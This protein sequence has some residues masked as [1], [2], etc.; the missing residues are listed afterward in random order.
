[1]NQKM[2]TLRQV[3]ETAGVSIATVSRVLNKAGGSAFTHQTA[4]HVKAV[5]TDLGYRP[6][7]LMRGVAGRSTRTVGVMI[8]LGMYYVHVVEGVH[9][10]LEE[11]DYAMILT[12]KRVYVPSPESE[13]ERKAMHRLLDRRVDG[14]ILRPTH[15]GVSDLYFEE[16]W[17]RGIPMVAVDR[18]LL[19]V[20]CDYVGT[21]NVAAGRIAAEHLLSLGHR[22]LA[23][24]AGPPTVSVVRDRRKGFEDAVAAFGGA[25]CVTVE[26]TESAAHQRDSIAGLLART[27]RPTGLFAMNDTLAEAV[28]AVAAEQGLT[29]PDDLSIVGCGNLPP[30]QYLVPSL[31]SFEQTPHAIGRQAA[32]FLLERLRSTEKEKAPRQVRLMPELV[33]R[34]STAA[35]GHV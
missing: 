7:L 19:G 28:Y 5:A 32:R 4:G 12:S 34:K 6:N 23:H 17:K 33:V 10:G 31:T 30:S 35:P 25:Y 24:L 11:A 26:T 3:A 1:M 14:I 8:P 22:Q 27:P 20:H 16:V 9:D 15:D 2:C 29:I 18:E 21:D 13:D